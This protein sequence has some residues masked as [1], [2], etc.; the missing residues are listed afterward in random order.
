MVVAP[1]AQQTVSALVD[2][3]GHAEALRAAPVASVALTARIT[4]RAEPAEALRCNVAYRHGL[5]GHTLMLADDQVHGIIERGEAPRA[6]HLRLGK[7]SHFLAHAHVSLD[8]GSS[9]TWHTGCDAGLDAASVLELADA[10]SS[11]SFAGAVQD[12]AAENRAKLA[13]IVARADG[14]E[15]SA[16]TIPNARHAANVMFNCMRG[17]IVADDSI[18]IGDLEKFLRTRSFAVCATHDDLLDTLEEPVRRADLLAAARATGDADFVRLC[19]EYMPLTFSRRHGDPSRPW[20]SFHIDIREAD[21]SRKLHFEGNWRDV[22]Q[23]W[24][25]L[26]LSFP[27]YIE[28]TIATFVNATTADGN[29]PYRIMRHGIDWER[30]DPEDPWAHIGYWGDHQIIYLLKLL[31]LYEAHEPGKL[32]T[33]LDADEYAFADV[34]YRIAS[35]EDLVRDP[36]DT[37]AFDK[38][39]DRHIEL[40]CEKEGADGNLVHDVAGRIVRATLAEKLLIPTLAKLGNFVP[41]GGIWMNTQRPEWNDANNA[42]VGNGV[43]VVTLA[44]LVR[45]VSFLQELFDGRADAFSMHRRPAEWLRTTRDVLAAHRD[46]DD[47]PATHRAM[48]DALGQAASDYRAAIYS[49]GLGER[50]AVAPQDVA[51]LLE[52]AGVL[53]TRSLEHNRRD[54]GLFHGYNLVDLSTEGELGLGRLEVMLEGQVAALSAGAIAPEQCVELVDALFE[55]PLYRADQNSFLLYPAKKLPLFLDRGIIPGDAVAASPLLSAL[56]DSTHPHVVR[57]VKGTQRFHPRVKDGKEFADALDELAATDPEFTDLVAAHRDSALA[58]YED[59]FDHRAYTGR[60]GSMYGYEGLG[61]IYWHMVSKLNLAMLEN[62]YWAKDQGASDEVLAAMTERY[63]RLREGL[64]DYKTFTEYGAFPP[65]AYSHTPPDQGAR[66]PGMTGQVKEDILTR[67]GELGIRILAGCIVFDP[68]MLRPS[69]F[70]TERATWSGITLSGPERIELDAGQLAT[71]ICQVPIV[72]TYDP[73]APSPA[74]TVTMADGSTEDF[75]G[76]HVSVEVSAKVFARSGEVVRIDVA[77]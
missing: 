35:Y 49:D 62:V 26:L 19:T 47:S 77:L 18:P 23:N 9:I 12:A 73:G 71:T 4:A 48:L 36:H 16:L 8:A 66:Q 3:Y 65:D 56:A 10:V 46:A 28:A 58:T 64:G 34:P 63:Y 40:R 20:N 5:P 60:S 15:T 11:D 37:I 27:E 53:L 45:H 25:A 14:F 68:V 39:L 30:P 17:G 75:A 76:G 72:Y 51:E 57:D 1:P 50:V 6:D 59:V 52:H 13:R 41:H 54:D 74:V 44:Y 22:F 2:A 69:E 43:S 32:A 42:L 7:P 21:G 31:E 29:N 24:E 38:D 33:L 55:G 67:R 61:S 70:L